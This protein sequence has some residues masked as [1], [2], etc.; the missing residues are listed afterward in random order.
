LRK[1]VHRSI[2]IC[3]IYLFIYF[4]VNI[5]MLTKLADAV[6]R[7]SVRSTLML[8]ISRIQSVPFKKIDT[9]DLSADHRVSIKSTPHP[10]A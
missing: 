6:T 8:S 10:A 3:F 5:P 2:L 7:T 9:A 4:D 1:A